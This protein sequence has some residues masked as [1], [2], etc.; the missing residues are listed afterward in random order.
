[1]LA[2]DPTTSSDTACDPI[3]SGSPVSAAHPRSDRG[4]LQPIDRCSPPRGGGRLVAVRLRG[5]RWKGWRVGWADIGGSPPAPPLREAPR[6]KAS[7]CGCRCGLPRW[8]SAAE[9]ISVRQFKGRRHC[10]LRSA[11]VRRG[12]D[13]VG[14]PWSFGG[15]HRGV[16]GPGFDGIP[17]SSACLR[18]GQPGSPVGGCRDGEDPTGA[19]G[20]DAGA[21]LDGTHAFGHHR[22]LGRREA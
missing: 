3:A 1:M 4:S 20:G 19:E 22:D 10:R 2:T 8:L 16:A 15:G 13:V 7:R 6:T 5:V 14:Q 17:R 11:G 9:S 18:R 12:G 21:D